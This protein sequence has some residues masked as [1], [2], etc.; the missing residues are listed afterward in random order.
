M[1]PPWG[2]RIRFEADIIGMKGKIF[3]RQEATS[4]LPLVRRIVTD[5]KA[6]TTLIARHKRGIAALRQQLEESAKGLSKEQIEAILVAIC[7]HEDKLTALKE[8]RSDCSQELEELGAFLDNAKSGVVKFY[9][10]I[11]SRIVY[12]TWKLGEVD[13]AFWHEIDADFADRQA[14]DGD[15]KVAQSA[16][17]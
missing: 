2:V 14:I 4:M 12:F 9:G 11:D 7:D 6:C 15:E 10:E 8:K 3:S 5:A 13:V 17:A 16:E 1:S